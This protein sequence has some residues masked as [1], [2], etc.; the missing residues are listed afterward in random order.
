MEK[1]TSREAAGGTASTSGGQS[2]GTLL[3]AIAQ[4]HPQGTEA[5]LSAALDRRWGELGLGTGWP[6]LIRI[7]P[8]RRV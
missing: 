4:E 5:E 7:Q 3:H 2:L 6:A 8:P 1:P